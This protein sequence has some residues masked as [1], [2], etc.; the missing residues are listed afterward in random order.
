MWQIKK[1]TLLKRQLMAFA[2]NYKNNVGEETAERF[3]DEISKA[4][5]FISNN[6]LACAIYLD[7]RE[8]KSLKQYEFRKWRVRIFPHSIIFRIEDET[9]ILEA[10]YAH[11][12]NATK[13]FPSE[14]NMGTGS[15]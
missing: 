12:M 4:I 5:E 10:V 2:H 3:I 7:A 14:R 13:R 15:V 11:K 9:I 8:E 6:P 1:S